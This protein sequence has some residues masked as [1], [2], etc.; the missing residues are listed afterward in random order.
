[1]S[2]SIRHRSSFWRGPIS[3]AGKARGARA[4]VD[5]PPE[6]G[7][8]R[9]CIFHISVI[10]IMH[11]LYK[12]VCAL[13]QSTRPT[14]T[15]RTTHSHKPHVIVNLNAA[16]PPRRRPLAGGVAGPLHVSP[17]VNGLGFFAW[18]LRR[19]QMF[20]PYL[21]PLRTRVLRAHATVG[22]RRLVRPHAGV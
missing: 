3:R 9:V 19:T 15:T 14:S 20:A 8:L 5:C 10:R 18:H 7:I 22:N 4:S 2:E 12:A 11:T 13:Y 17:G 6:R 21:T 1:M 16:L